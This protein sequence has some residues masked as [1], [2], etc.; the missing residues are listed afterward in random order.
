VGEEMPEGFQSA[1]FLLAHGFVDA[2]VPRPELRASLSRLLR[3][4]PVAAVDDGQPVGDRP[5]GPLGALSGLAERLG[6]AVS[7]T[8]GIDVEAPSDGN[9][10]GPTTAPTDER[11]E[12]R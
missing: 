5:R 3:L 6:G 7:E 4:L 2:V 12:A 10:R 9:G 8:I 1:E 11:E